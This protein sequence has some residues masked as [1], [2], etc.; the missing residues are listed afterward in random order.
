M[1]YQ[2]ALAKL[3]PVHQEHLLKFWDSL[4]PAEQKLLLA[5]IDQLNIET[6]LAQQAV[7]SRPVP[8]DTDKIEPCREYAHSGNKEDYLLGKQLIAKG[9]A[10]CLIVAGGQGTRLRFDGPKGMFPIT[11]VMRKSLFQLFA[12]KTLSASKQSNHPLPL[13]IMTSPLN[14]AVI[15]E[16]FTKNNYFG[17]LASQLFFFTQK[18]LPFLDS[19]GNMFLDSPCSISKGP[20]GNG[21]SL[22]YFHESGIWQQWQN[23]GIEQV[24]YLQID[25]PLADP[26]DAELLGFHHRT[27]ADATIKCVQR[28]DANEKVGVLVKKGDRIAVVEYSELPFK[29]VSQYP[30]ANISLF[31]FSMD[32]IK[33]AGPLPF[34]ASF[35]AAKTLDG[36]PAEPNAWKMETFIFDNLS[37]K[38]NAL[39][40]PREECFSPLKDAEGV[41][42]VQQALQASDIEV[43]KKVS[44]FP[45]PK[46][47]FELS[48]D[49]YYPTPFLLSVWQDRPFP[50]KSYITEGST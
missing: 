41:K 1:N 33:T 6:F 10:G 50:D 7:I 17:L 9:K 11:P 42:R 13:A 2:S 24:N 8:I 48:Q 23:L 34:H 20:D 46:Q 32:F 49:F 45:P 26:F 38:V 12:E 29:E 14:D 16:F 21:Y 31:C 27:K 39:L 4:S 30:L 36:T 25:N 19:E 22:R 28:L 43:V 37:N 40:Y 3:Q 47:P 18:L 35:K 44:G 5:D 15:K